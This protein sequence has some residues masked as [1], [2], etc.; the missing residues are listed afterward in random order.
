[1]TQRLYHYENDDR[2]AGVSVVMIA[3]MA[4]V[5]TT[6]IVMSVLSTQSCSV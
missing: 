5:I 6:L 3:V 1:M 4:V 2:V